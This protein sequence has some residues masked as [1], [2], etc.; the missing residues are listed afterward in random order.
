MNHGTNAVLVRGRRHLARKATRTENEAYL[1]HMRPK[2]EERRQQPLTLTSTQQ[3][4]VDYFETMLLRELRVRIPV[5]DLCD[6]GHPGF[7]RCPVCPW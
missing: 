6:L 2:R 7:G 1:R 4:E 5:V 3:P